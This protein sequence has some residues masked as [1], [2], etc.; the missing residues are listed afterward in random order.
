MDSATLGTG[1]TSSRS[2]VAEALGGET[3]RSRVLSGFA[4]KGGSEIA[5]VSS[6]IVVAIA[7]ARL[8]APHDYG[9]VG[10]VIVFATIAPIFSDLALGAA[11]IHREHLTEADRSTVFWISVATGTLL[12]LGFI[13]L[14]GPLASYYGEPDVRPLFIAFSSIFV[15]GSL[16]ATQFALLTREMNF[17]GLETRVMA[18]TVLGAVVGI[19]IAVL[20]GGAWAIIGQQVTV[21]L[22]S[23]VLLWH[24]S[25]WHPR[26]TFSM[27][28]LRR[29]GGYSGNVFGSHAILQAAPNVHNLLIGRWAGAAAL[30]SF[31]LAQNVILMPF[32][33]IAAPIETVLFPAFSR[34]QDEPE[35]IAGLWL[36]VNRLVA[37]IAF[38]CLLG[39]AAVA[40][41]FVDVV[42]GPKWQSATV[43]IQ[44]L[45]WVGILQ[46]LQRLNFSILQARNHTRALFW[47]SIFSFA[48]GTAAVAAGLHWGVE[49]VALA[50]AIASTVT[51]PLFTHVT[52]RAVG[53]SL[54]D[55]VINIAGVAQASLGMALA[56]IG[57]RHVLVDAGVAPLPRLLLSILVGVAVFAALAAWRAPQLRG[58]VQTLRNR[59]RHRQA[60]PASPVT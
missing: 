32:Y 60:V 37:A 11:L 39:L 25:P 22:V 19:G 34:L 48:A 44:I 36:R 35:R 38:P 50:A 57:V 45:C 4:W 31:T 12:T 47:F 14:S 42:L 5:L 41:D 21:T 58:E 28:S 29:L 46:A 16:G 9:L 30:G 43:V 8:L 24:F 27:Q 54:W 6:K 13:L 59:L 55:C 7:L 40:P 1:G 53:S 3:L 49:G 51:L 20:G 10:M 17:R 33:R 56:I 26:F 52:A 15:L 18:S 2:A 23:T